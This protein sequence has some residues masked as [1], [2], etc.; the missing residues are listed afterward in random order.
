MAGGYV[1]IM[2]PSGYGKSTLINILG[3]RLGIIFQSY[4]LIRA[5][6]QLGLFDEQNRGLSV[7]QGRW[8]VSTRP[9]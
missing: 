4:N 2:G 9:A 7:C 1:S 3:A 8:P 5:P 6:L